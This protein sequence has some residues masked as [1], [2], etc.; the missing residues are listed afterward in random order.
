MENKSE[1]QQQSNEVDQLPLFNTTN[2]MREVI[3]ESVENVRISKEAQNFM[4][5]LAT[6]FV[7]FLSSEF[8]SFLLFF[9]LFLY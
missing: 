4:V 2:I 9:L 1:S 7:L 8:V 6:E 3:K 5:E